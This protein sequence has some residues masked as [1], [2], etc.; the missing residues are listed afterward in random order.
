MIL[1]LDSRLFVAE[2]PLELGQ[3]PFQELEPAPDLAGRLLAAARELGA[4]LLAAARQLV[5]SLAAAPH[6]PVDQIP[7]A[8]ARCL[9]RARRGA[10]RP[11]DGGAHGVGY[12]A[13]LGRFGAGAWSCR[14]VAHPA[15]EHN[16]RPL[17]AYLRP[18]AEIAADVLLPADPGLAMVLAQRLTDQPLMANHHH[19]L[20]GYTGRAGGGAALT[21]QATGIG[22]PSAAVVLT[23]LAA[24]GAR[25]AI[26]IGRAT[27]LAPSLRAGDAIVVGAAIGADGTSAALGSE[28]ASP[29]AALTERLVTITGVGAA[30]IAS[31]DTLASDPAWAQAGAVAVDRETAALLALA[32]ALGL[33]LAAGV[34][35]SRE[36][37]GE[38]DD[39]A[40]DTALLALADAAATALATA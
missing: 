27:A 16:P 4:G 6:H 8:I 22:A 19:G 36:L 11:L 33:E 20:W 1:D 38:G 28:R 35:V 31:H 9:R 29:A 25:R 24:H 5:A 21:V 14:S 13:L 34:V 23:E 3:A 7:G 10:H 39:E 40:V 2:P 17:D 30:T 32:R 26:R 37:D 15:S 18:T 12:A